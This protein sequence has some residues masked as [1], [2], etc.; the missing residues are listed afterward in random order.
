MLLFRKSINM[1]R[2]CL[3]FS[4]IDAVPLWSAFWHG[5]RY[6]VGGFFLFRGF[7]NA[8]EIMPGTIPERD[9]PGMAG[10][11]EK[12]DIPLSIE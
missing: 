10:S 6:R 1:N 9:G 7:R 11:R 12:D 2:L 8:M 3:F 5:L 4:V